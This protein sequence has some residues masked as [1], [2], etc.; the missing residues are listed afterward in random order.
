MKLSHALVVSLALVVLVVLFAGISQAR[1]MI[2]VRMI[3]A[4][5]PPFGSTQWTDDKGNVVPAGCGPEAARMLLAY[6]DRRYGYEQLVRGQPGKAIVEL[7]DRMHTITVTWDG[8]KQGF[9]D[10]TLF[11]SGLKSYME[12]H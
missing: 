6:Y 2:P 9:T 12:A 4:G 3:I 11:K 10:P 8:K 1:D 7:H 5:V